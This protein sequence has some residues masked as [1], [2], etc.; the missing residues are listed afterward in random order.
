MRSGG[1]NLRQGA[2]VPIEGQVIS[3]GK[4]VERGLPLP[5][6]KK[7]GGYVQMDDQL[8]PGGITMMQVGPGELW[9]VYG[10]T[11]GSEEPVITRVPLL[12]LAVLPGGEVV[13]VGRCPTTGQVFRTDQ[14]DIEGDDVPSPRY[15]L[16][17]AAPG[18]VEPDWVSLLTERNEC[19]WWWCELC[20]EPREWPTQEYE[21]YPEY[22]RICRPCHDAL[23]FKAA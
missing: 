21:C 23:D 13:G 1:V 15:L 14:N 11:H 22:G 12:G 5:P 16:G 20:E 18:V 2:H 17:F 7:K 6:I 19:G 4:Q 9:A 8:T 3:K 10:F